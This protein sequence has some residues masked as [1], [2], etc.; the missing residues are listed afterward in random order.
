MKILEI[1]IPAIRAHPWAGNQATESKSRLKPAQNYPKLR[2]FEKQEKQ[3]E[4]SCM[5]EFSTLEMNF[6]SADAAN[7]VNRDPGGDYIDS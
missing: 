2:K 1:Q 6:R 3:Q 5:T 7:H 4:T